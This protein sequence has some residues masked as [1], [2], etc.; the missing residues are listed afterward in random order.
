MDSTTANLSPAVEPVYRSGALKYLKN[1]LTRAHAIVFVV[2]FVVY[3][4]LTFRITNAGLDDGPE[5]D[6]RVFMSTLCTMAGPLTGA[7][8][9][10]FQGCCLRFSLLVMTYCAP[11]LLVC[12]GLQFIRIPDWRWRRVARLVF[13]TLGWF[14]WFAGGILSFGHALS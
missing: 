11:V 12:V 13:W 1:N 9:R 3:T 2:L 4:L 10:G 7:I 6:S 8:S 5:H 14:I